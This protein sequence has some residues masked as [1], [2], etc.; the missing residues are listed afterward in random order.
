MT[1]IKE[2]LDALRAN[3][4]KPEPHLSLTPD[5]MTEQVVNDEL[6]KSQLKRLKTGERSLANAQEKL[7]ADLNE[8]R[9][10]G[11]ERGEF[12]AISHTHACNQKL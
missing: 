10:K 1:V 2:E 11:K 7:R 5:G 4:A 12:N 9:N 8:V 6:Y 3:L